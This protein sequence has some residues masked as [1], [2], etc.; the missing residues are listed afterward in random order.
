MPSV[1]EEQYEAPGSP[2]PNGFGIP[3]PAAPCPPNR[4]EDIHRI[5]ETVDRYNPQNIPVLESYVEEQ[6]ERDVYDRDA[7]LAVLKLYQFNP[8][9]NNIEVVTNILG[10]ALGALPDPDFNLCLYM[11][12]EDILTDNSVEKLIHLHHLLEQAK[13]QEFWAYLNTTEGARDLVAKY[14]HFDRRIREYASVTVGIAYQAIEKE[15]LGEYLA[16]EGVDL[17]QWIAEKGWNVDKDSKLV[18]LPISKENQARPVIVQESIKFEQLT[19]I[20]GYG[21]LTQ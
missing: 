20:I 2:V 9:F 8:T 21:R 15:R 18:N 13:F 11:L 6:M 10:L 12:N 3:S 1:E 16:L 5:V 14:L 19:K 17:D 4:P 7:C